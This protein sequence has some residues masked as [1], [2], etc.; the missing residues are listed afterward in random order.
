MPKNVLIKQAE[1]LLISL[2]S[3]VS[4]TE[5]SDLILSYIELLLPN[6]VPHLS[7]VRL[8]LNESYLLDILRTQ[9]IHGFDVG[10]ICLP[11]ILDLIESFMVNDVNQGFLSHDWMANDELFSCA[12]D[13]Y[14]KENQKSG[15]TSEQLQ[16]L[17]CRE[18]SGLLTYPGFTVAHSEVLITKLSPNFNPLEKINPELEL[19]DTFLDKARRFCKPEVI[20][21]LESLAP[22][23]IPEIGI[24][25][26]PFEF[27]D[28]YELLNK[29]FSSH[30]PMEIKKDEFYK[31]K[32][33]S[34]ISEFCNNFE[35]VPN[36][37]INQINEMRMQYREAAPEVILKVVKDSY[38]KSLNSLLAIKQLLNTGE[39]Q[40][41][42][43]NNIQT[44]NTFS[45]KGTSKR[46]SNVGTLSFMGREVVC[47]N[48]STHDGYSPFITLQ[49][50]GNF[51]GKVRDLRRKVP[52]IVEIQPVIFL[53]NINGVIKIEYFMDLAPGKT[54]R[55]IKDLS[56][57]EKESIMMQ[58]DESVRLMINAGYALYDF[59]DDNVLWDG[60]QLTFIDLSFAGFR[61]EALNDADTES[62][63][64][65]MKLMLEK[66]ITRNKVSEIVES[67]PLQLKEVLPADFQE[68]ESL[69]T[70]SPQFFSLF[71]PVLKEID[72][73]DIASVRPR[74]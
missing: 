54:L 33:L 23:I 42:C 27:K 47:K 34:S 3:D 18:M 5:S 61:D 11:G 60:K 50:L 65:T 10:T 22:D 26:D 67:N 6:E 49:S 21:Y 51:I 40:I 38:Q 32:S 15:C 7:I 57:Q 71:K 8:S 43:A 13:V 62:V 25:I 31:L 68:R 35:F 24:E 46:H 64:S 72:V 12:L 56:I 55:N 69:N 16:R 1:K 9:L 36:F 39:I 2:E 17:L 53:D 74:I 66:K 30:T 52:N 37:F 14:I 29:D 48:Y 45:G 63:I 4:T 59:N 20:S 70:G 44:D 19:S 28:I 73:E 58:F 41:Y